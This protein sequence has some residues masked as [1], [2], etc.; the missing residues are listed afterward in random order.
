MVCKCLIRN[1]T[2]TVQ[3]KKI[4]VRLN[5][6]IQYKNLNKTLANIIQ[7][8]VRTQLEE[9]CILNEVDSSQ[10]EKAGLILEN[11]LT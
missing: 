2:K 11:L 3:T 9:E 7:Q 8:Y 4:I 10:E 1:L 6:I 5:L